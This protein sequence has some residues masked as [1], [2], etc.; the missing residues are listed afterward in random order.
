VTHRVNFAGSL[1]KWSKMIES[2]FESSWRLNA[3]V[4]PIDSQPWFET[5]I[6][7]EVEKF[8]VMLELSKLRK[9]V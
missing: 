1:Y 3:A 5:R 2:G 4:G 7:F 6:A 9:M 8:L